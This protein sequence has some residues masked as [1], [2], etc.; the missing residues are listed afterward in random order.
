[1]GCGASAVRAAGGAGRPAVRYE[2]RGH[3]TG[4]GGAMRGAGRG[5]GN[6]RG[7][8]LARPRRVRVGRAEENG[9]VAPGPAVRWGEG[10]WWW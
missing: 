10:T 9:V 2:G 5:G 8:A 1:M 7:G 6:A 4:R 3:C